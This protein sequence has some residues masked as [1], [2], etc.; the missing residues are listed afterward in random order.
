[1]THTGQC[2]DL[3]GEMAAALAHS[4]LA[5]KGRADLSALYWGKA[6]QAFKQTG[7]L[8]L[9]ITGKITAAMFSSSRDTLTVLQKYYNSQ[10][11]V[12]HVF[13]GAASMW[14]ACKTLPAF[15]TESEASKFKDI[16]LALSSVTDRQGPRW[17][18]E[19]PGWDN[20]WW[21]A[22]MLMAQQ[23]EKGPMIDGQ[24]AFPGFLNVFMNRWVNGEVDEYSPIRCAP[25][26]HCMKGMQPPRMRIQC[27]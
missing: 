11:P 8:N 10:S 27:R 4:A 23:G 9:D 18:W 24:I 15:C 12:S 14:V 20:A 25:A 17:Y 2:S 6:N 26:E 5:F 1:M 13:F 21:E 7:A 22:A 19:A 3:A 16:A